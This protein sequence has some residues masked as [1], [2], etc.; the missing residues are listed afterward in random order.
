MTEDKVLQGPFSYL[1]LLHSQT[2]TFVPAR[3]EYGLYTFTLK[4]GKQKTVMGARIFLSEKAGPHAYRGMPYIDIGQQKLLY[5]LRPLLDRTVPD[6]M[7]YSVTA[8]GSA[9]VTEYQ[10]SV[11]QLA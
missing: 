3:W 2:L 6:I 4:A 10:V 7:E 9:P 1:E 11:R 8:I 5:Q